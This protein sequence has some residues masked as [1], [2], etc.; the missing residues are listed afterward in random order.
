MLHLLAVQVDGCLTHAILVLNDAE[1]QAIKASH[2]S[3]S[4]LQMQA[5]PAT[6]QSI[7]ASLIA[8]RLYMLMLSTPTSL[9]EQANMVQSN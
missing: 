5:N 9:V 7:P 2:H 4:I 6:P 1:L 8:H 3:L